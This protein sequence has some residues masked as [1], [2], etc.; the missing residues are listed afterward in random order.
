MPRAR[1]MFPT[2]LGVV[3]SPDLLARV[4]L[5]RE[6]RSFLRLQFLTVTLEGGLLERLREPASFSDLVA[7][8]ASTP[9]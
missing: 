1:E 8:I 7:L 9:A 4:L 2:V 6:L 3:R 5:R